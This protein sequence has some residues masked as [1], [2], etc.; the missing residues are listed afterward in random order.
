MSAMA[1]EI[2]QRKDRVITTT[3]TKILEPLPSQT[4]NLLVEKDEERLLKRL[5]QQIDSYAHITV[6]SQKLASGKLKGVNPELVVKLA[7][8]RQ[9]S[10]IIIEADGAAQKPLKAPNTTEPLIPGNTSLVIPVVGIDAL[11]CR[12]TKDAV[13]RPEIASALLEVPIGEII[14]AELIARLV[15]HPR[16]IA[17]GSPVAARIVPFINKVDLNGGLSKGRL[18]ARK[19]LL[20][21]HPRI[22]KVILGQAQLPNPVMEI[23]RA[24]KFSPTL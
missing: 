20:I 22:E 5:L 2:V 15:T 1:R 14:T 18:L 10:Y 12:L 23:I 6:A 8:I 21:E 9:I 3:T 19:I 13:F 16:G 11:G 4:R 17:K 7:G 24:V